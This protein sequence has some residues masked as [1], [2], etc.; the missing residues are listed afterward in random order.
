MLASIPASILN[1]TRG[2]LGIPSR[3]QLTQTCSKLDQLNIVSSDPEASM[4]FYRRLG[5]DI[6]ERMV[7]RTATGAHHI[8]AQR[9]DFNF[10][11]DS[12]PFAQVW[13]SGWKGRSDLAG[14]VVVGFSVDSREAV[15]ALYAD[16]T[17]AGYKGL[18][19]PWDAFWGAR[20]AMVE[21]PDGVAVGLMSSISP[22][23]RY[24]PPEV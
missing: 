11:I 17:G 8:T 22:E 9:D 13:S 15:A 19:P 12:T 1:L 21:D 10:E 4:A 2:P 5:M 18:Q 23:H 14:R 7:W 16:L 6:P 3:F 20:Y 24:P